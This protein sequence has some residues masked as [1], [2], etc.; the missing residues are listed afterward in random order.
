LLGSSKAALL[1]ESTDG[2]LQLTEQADTGF[3]LF[4]HQAKRKLEGSGA[5]VKDYANLRQAVLELYLSVKIR[6]DDEIDLYNKDMFMQ[7]QQ[8]LAHVD[9]YTLIDNIKSSIET[10]MN[11]KMEESQEKINERYG[12]DI[13]EP[14]IEV[15]LPRGAL[16]GLKQATQDYKLDTAEMN[17]ALKKSLELDKRGEKKEKGVRKVVQKK[18]GKKQKDENMESIGH[19][20]TSSI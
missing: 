15:E 4:S 6:S 10:L 5:L 12:K 11:M 13:E 7:E 8:E 19:S 9:G 17:E 16:E 20:D 3:N 18:K 14:D 1:R 2:P